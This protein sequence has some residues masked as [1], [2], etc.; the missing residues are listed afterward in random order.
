MKEMFKQNGYFR[1]QIN[2]FILSKNAESELAIVQKNFS[3]L[4]KDPYTDSKNYRFRAYS[5]LILLPWKRKMFWIPPKYQAGQYLSSY[6]QGDFNLEHHDKVRSFTPLDNE[7]KRT[8]L[9]NNLILHDY[10]LT[11]WR[12]EYTYT[13]LYVG[14]HFVKLMVVDPEHIAFSSPDLVHRDGEAFTF[15]HLFH[16]SNIVGGTNYIAT[17]ESANHKLEELKEQNIMEKFE[18]HETFDSYGVCDEMVSHYVSPIKLQDKNLMMG[19]REIILIDFSP[20]K[21]WIN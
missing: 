16:R 6:W 5:N 12:N 18:L 2:P 8:D 1:T 9:I 3:S 14:I 21:Q 20:M 19:T 15:A 17:P 10:D 11:F 13:P 4:P 7:T